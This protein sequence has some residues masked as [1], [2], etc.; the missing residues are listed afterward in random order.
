MPGGGEPDAAAIIAAMEA[1]TGRTCEAIVGKPWRHTI[2]AILAL[3]RA[4]AAARLMTGDRLETDICMGLDAGMAT[5]L[6]LTGAMAASAL[7]G[8]AVQPTYVIYQLADL[9]MD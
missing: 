6:T 4:P 5:A 8:S 1:C 3:V 9:V 2:D 7:A